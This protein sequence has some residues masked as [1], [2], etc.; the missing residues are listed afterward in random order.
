[1]QLYKISC[2]NKKSEEEFLSLVARR[3]GK[4]L[5]G[6]IPDRIAAGRIV[7]K[8]WNA[9]RIPFFTLPPKTDN[10]Q[11][12]DEN[13]REDYFQ[14]LVSGWWWCVLISYYSYFMIYFSGDCPVQLLQGV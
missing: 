11:I 14:C 1:M 3:Y 6:G 7:L 13:V 10:K 9:G 4:L 5:K 12:K 8:D 2:F